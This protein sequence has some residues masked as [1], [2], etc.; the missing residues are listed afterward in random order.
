M[1][2]ISSNNHH[3]DADCLARR[4]KRAGG[5]DH[6]AAAGPS[7]VKEICSANGLA[8]EE[9]QPKRPYISFTAMEVHPTVAAV[10]KQSH[11]AATCPFGSRSA[12]RL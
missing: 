5:N 6:V 2:L 12:S 7:R 8:E 9:D 3:S 10:A 1:V 4:L 11:K